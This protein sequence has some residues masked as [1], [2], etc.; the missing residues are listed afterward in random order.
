[1]RRNPKQPCPDCTKTRLCER[2]RDQ[3]RR[4]DMRA[5]AAGDGPVAEAEEWSL[6]LVYH[7]RPFRLTQTILCSTG[8]TQTREE[9]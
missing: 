1:M 2:C 5:D 7:Q 6:P 3:M 8:L 4:E 9:Q